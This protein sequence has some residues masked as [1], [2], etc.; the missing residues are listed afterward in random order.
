MKDIILVFEEPTRKVLKEYS[1]ISIEYKVDSVYNLEWKNN[2]LG[3]IMIVEEAIDPYYKNY[4]SI[5]DNPSLLLEEFNLENWSVVSA[6][7]GDTRIGGAIIAYNTEG[8]NMLEG[9][10]DLVII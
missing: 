6:F 5:D 10:D 4:D 3:G 2:G 9:R 1:N 8:V 7:D